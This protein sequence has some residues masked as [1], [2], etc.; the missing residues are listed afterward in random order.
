MP[1]TNEQIEA[2]IAE[3]A[4]ENG[5]KIAEMTLKLQTDIANMNSTFDAEVARLKTTQEL[6]EEKRPYTD[7]EMKEKRRDLVKNVKYRAKWDKV[8]EHSYWLGG[9]KYLKYMGKFTIPWYMEDHPTVTMKQIRSVVGST[10][11][12]EYRT[13]QEFTLK[14]AKEMLKGTDGNYKRS[15]G[16]CGVDGWVDAAFYL[17]DEVWCNVAQ[18]V[19]LKLVKKFEK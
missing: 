4:E 8:V 15:F 17:P 13:F 16:E 9:Q 7:E 5:R 3:L 14:V 18:D 10:N 6:P 19:F 1:E 12:D 11:A 2:K